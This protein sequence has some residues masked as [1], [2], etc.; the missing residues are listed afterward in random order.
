MSF[1]G[2]TLPRT[3]V[4]LLR[5][6]SN[7]V[8]S[9]YRCLVIPVNFVRTAP[10]AQNDFRRTEKR[11]FHSS[12]RSMAT[13]KDPYDTL[14]VDRS[15]SASEIKK[16]YYQAAKKWHPD[17]NKD[18]QARE[19]FQEIQAAY[20]ILSD[21]Q[22]KEQFDQYGES[23]FDP[24]GGFTGA[25][26]G[27][28]FGGGP[29]GFSGFGGG[30]GGDFSFED[31]FS[32]F[33]GAQ[34]GGRRRRGRGGFEEVLVGD[35][36]DIATTISF[37]DAAKG[38]EQ[39]I[40]IQPIVSCST[41]SSSGTK[42]GAKHKECGRCGGTGTRIRIMTGGFQM[43]STCESCGG[44]G[45]VI[46]KGSECDSCHGNGTVR[47]TRTIRIPIPAG[48]DDGM[49]LRIA[50]EGDAPAMHVPGANVRTRRGDLIVHIRVAPHKSFGRKGADILYT[51][52]IPFTTAILGGTVKIPTLD[53]EVE[54]RV[55][56]GTNTGD[57]ITMTGMGMPKLESGGRGVGD[58][59]VEFKVNMPKSLTTSQRTLLEMLADEMKDK[60]ARRVMDL[61]KYREETEA[62]KKNE[63][64]S[65]QEHKNDNFLKRAWDRL[66]HHNEDGDSNKPSSGGSDH[67]E[68]PKKA[69]GSGSS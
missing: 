36:I 3:T 8:V 52:T 59:K 64:S 58:L 39:E 54:L 65:S 45:L 14:G 40:R 35:N 22:K 43:A 53:G 62:A 56:T 46:P 26:A 1:V 61:H 48:A 12:P 57:K 37:T 67:H 25:G 7:I 44:T 24:S 13:L 19:K 68:P 15:A 2:P 51:A 10:P 18:P 49:K 55:P 6:T 50:G 16:A 9:Q 66:T 30:F 42:P 21:P 27:A 63:E 38:G 47:E 69:S 17:T 23:A 5:G 11:A 29:G 31:L 60:S 34:G 33:A 20:E 32:A 4:R 41:C 28:G